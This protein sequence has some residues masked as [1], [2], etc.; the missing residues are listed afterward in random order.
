MPKQRYKIMRAYMP[1]RGSMGLDMMQSTCSTQVT[2]DF[3]DEADMVKKFRVSLALQPVAEALFANS[4]FAQARDSGFLSYRSK[5]WANTDPQRCG[6]LPFAFQQGMSFERYTDYVL[7]VP[8][9]FVIREGQYIDAS[10]LSFRDFLDGR[11]AVLPGQKPVLSDWVNHLSTV[12]PHVRLKRQ[13]EMRGADAGDAVLRVPALAALWAGLLYDVDA[14]DTACE[15]IRDWTT[16]ERH[17]LTVGVAKY[18][19][20]TPFRKGTVRDLSLWMLELSRAGLERRD[21]LDEQGLNECDYLN[22][23]QAA[24]EAGQTFAEELLLRL[25]REWQGDFDTAIRTLCEET[26]S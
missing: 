10:G 23:L 26:L 21:N 15:R 6:S 25:D 11:L 3:C 5:I 17:D 2:A 8:M 20:R 13:L 19:F 22:P 18:G 14:L 24:A 16:P 1:Q 7:D 9:Y 12:F 4:P